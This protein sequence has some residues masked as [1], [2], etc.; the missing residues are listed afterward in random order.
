M[1]KMMI[2]VAYL[3]STDGSVYATIKTPPMSAADCLHSI[4]KLK[5]TE[6]VRYECLFAEVKP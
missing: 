5:S 2:L 1:L 3:M 4:S 6:S